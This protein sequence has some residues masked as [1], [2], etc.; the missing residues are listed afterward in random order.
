MCSLA[1]SGAS[2]ATA[3]T[4]QAACTGT[5]LYVLTLVM[6]ETSC[7]AY[8]AGGDVRHEVDTYRLTRSVNSPLSGLLTVLNIFRIF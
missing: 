8:L 4:I 1:D 7:S 5:G 2:L 3:D 6:S